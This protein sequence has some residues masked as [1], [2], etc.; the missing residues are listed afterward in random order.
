MG[1]AKKRL[2]ESEVCQDLG[3]QP[4]PP[5]LARSDQQPPQPA[6]EML[7]NRDDKA[8]MVELAHQSLEVIVDARLGNQDEDDGGGPFRVFVQSQ[9]DQESAGVKEPSQC[10]LDLLKEALSYEFF[11]AVSSFL[12]M[13]SRTA[14]GLQTA[15]M[16]SRK[17][18]APRLHPSPSSITTE[19][20]SSIKTSDLY[21]PSD[22]GISTDIG[23]VCLNGI[24]SGSAT[25]LWIKC[26]RGEQSFSG[27]QLS[28][29]AIALLRS[30][31]VSEK[32]LHK[33]GQG[34]PP[35]GRRS[36][37][38]SR[39]LTTVTHFATMPANKCIRR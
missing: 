19:M 38:Y 8:D 22:F 30:V 9:A 39:S 37:T 2:P 25:V 5:S 21:D 7:S 34:R 3:S 29:F 32:L 14:T 6:H 18:A 24:L 26:W 12:L 28:S 27:S 1:K 11:S 31:I 17:A 13:G 36:E 33:L 4:Y 35:N 10:R 20:T 23:R 16:A 15:W